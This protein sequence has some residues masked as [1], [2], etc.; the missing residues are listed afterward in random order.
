MVQHLSPIVAK[1]QSNSNTNKKISQLLNISVSNNSSQANDHPQHMGQP[2]FNNSTAMTNQQQQQQQQPHMKKYNYA[3]NSS[4]SPDQGVNVNPTHPYYFLNSMYL[5][6]Q[7]QAMH[8]H[9]QP[10]PA[11]MIPFMSNSS[12]LN[13][14]P[15]N[16]YSFNNP[17]SINPLNIPYNMNSNGNL[18]NY[19]NGANYSNVNLAGN[20][21]RKKHSGLTSS[22]PYVSAF[23]SLPSDL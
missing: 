14:N 20:A 10:H 3:G 19:S 18:S 1:N 7:Q 6:Y 22:D 15:N 21:N 17:S 11:H 4:A 13:Y 23:S 16:S 5:N 9:A 8:S 2:A 12:P